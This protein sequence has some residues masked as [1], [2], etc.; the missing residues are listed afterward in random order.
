MREAL[1]PEGEWLRFCESFSH[2]H[3]GWPVRVAVIDTAR[4]ESG[5]NGDSV[6]FLVEDQP[7]AGILAVRRGADREVVIVTGD[8]ATQTSQTVKQPTALIALHA[9][10]GTV[11]ALRI[12]SATGWSTLLSFPA[13][14][15]T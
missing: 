7:L 9:I 13:M 11:T 15:Q 2:G 8:G 4:L 6:D 5:T 3:R 12:D 1:I 10:N 14:A